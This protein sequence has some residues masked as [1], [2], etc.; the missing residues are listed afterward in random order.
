MAGLSDAY[1]DKVLDH[2]FRTATLAKL[3]NVYVGL[4]DSDP[5][6]AALAT[7]LTIGVGAYAR[8]IV[9]VANASWTAPAAAG[10]ARQ[11]TNNILITFP[12]PTANWN[13]GNPIDYASL[14]DAPT[15]GV[16]IASGI[17][18][19]PRVILD[20]DSNPQFGFGALVFTLT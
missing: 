12:D 17:L 14:W 16:M 4:N 7:E 2:L 15:G 13:G 8:V 6:D 20:I 9:P 18:T 10:G 5:T 3:T 1:A 19:T 11:I